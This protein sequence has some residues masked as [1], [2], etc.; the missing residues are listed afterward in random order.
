[1]TSNKQRIVL[2][3]EGTSYD[4]SKDHI[5]VK[6]T[7]DLSDLGGGARWPGCGAKAPT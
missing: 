3:G 7:L 6:S 5:H 4:W 1:M 2:P